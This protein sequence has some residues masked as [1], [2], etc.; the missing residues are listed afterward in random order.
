MS[1]S[2]GGEP[3]HSPPHL[4]PNPRL[5]DN[6]SVSH[7]SLIIDCDPGVDDGVALLLAFASPELNLLGVT[8][9]A[10]NVGA[11]LTARNA[12]IVRAIAGR[13]DVPVLAGCQRPMVRVPVEAG[14]FHGESG[15]G[16]LDLPDVADEPGPHAVDFIVRTLMDRPPGTVDIV[17]TGPFTNLAMA[18]VLEPAIAQ[19]IRRVVVMGGARAEGGNITASAEY[20]IFA[21]P[22]AAHVVFASGV[23]VI[24]HGLDATHQVRA[25]ED[26]IAAIEALASPRAA[27][28]ASL[29]R[30][31]RKIEHEIVRG[32]DAPLHDPC[33]IAWLID[34]ALFETVPCQVTVETASPL[35]L[36]HTAVEFRDAQA[37]PHRWVTTADGQGVFDLITA[38]LA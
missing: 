37:S 2:G 11:A 38:R 1:G 27:A 9:V 31:S 24:V 33:P 30:F 15:L 12:R 34:E 10:G 7:S 22:H 21:D 16:D 35:T 3:S 26:R 25:T 4:H 28:A 23:P 14:H 20:N 19:R 32:L 6:G 18:M 36:G 8:T 29:L 5:A 13:P 17:V